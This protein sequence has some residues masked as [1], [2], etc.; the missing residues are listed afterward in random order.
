MVASMSAADHLD[1]HPLDAVTEG[2][3]PA[4]PSMGL[5]SLLFALNVATG[6]P[7]EALQFSPATAWPR[8]RSRTDGIIQSESLW[9][10]LERP[11]INLGHGEAVLGDVDERLR[12]LA[13]LLDVY[14]V[15]DW[16]GALI[17]IGVVSADP[18]LPGGTST[19]DLWALAQE[20]R[21][22]CGIEHW[23]HDGIGD[24]A[25][26]ANF[27]KTMQLVWMRGD[28]L[29]TVSVSCIDG[30]QHWMRHAV[31]SVATLVDNQLRASA[32]T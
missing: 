8:V 15:I 30:G 18:A 10:M 6:L 19:S 22:G 20:A 24:A 23:T 25:C 29:A 13:V 16:S 17:S 12:G 27:G 21:V 5:I 1:P 11:I 3:C 28:R 31:R 2:A 4:T 26:L 32:A 14:R 7:P 9:A